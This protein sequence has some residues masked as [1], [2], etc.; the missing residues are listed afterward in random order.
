MSGLTGDGEWLWTAL[1]LVPTKVRDESRSENDYVLLA[2]VVGGL[3][4]NLG[5]WMTMVDHLPYMERMRGCVGV[6]ELVRLWLV[7]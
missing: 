7:G 2:S 4:G 1:M 3:Q 5:E 6:G